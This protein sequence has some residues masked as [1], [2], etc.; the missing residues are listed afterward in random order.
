M[1]S[2][3]GSF[4]SRTEPVSLMSPALADGFFTTS[5]IWQLMLMLFVS[6]VNFSEIVC[7]HTYVLVSMYV[8]MWVYLWVCLYIYAVLL[9]YFFHLTVRSWRLFLSLHKVPT[10][11]VLWLYPSFFMAASWWTL[12]LFPTLLLLYTK[13]QWIIM[14][15]CHFPKCGNMFA[16]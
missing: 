4:W 14:F 12:T 8:W 11:P 1:P 10:H 5:T 16:K 13:L 6:C 7:T 3:R 9:S 2:S 15:I